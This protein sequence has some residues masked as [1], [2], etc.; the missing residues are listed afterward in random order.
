MDSSDKTPTL[1]QRVGAVLA[2]KVGKLAYEAYAQKAGGKTFDGKPMPTWDTL[3]Q[4]Q[5]DQWDFAA[6]AV[7]IGVMAVLRQVQR[8]GAPI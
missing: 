1:G 4:P 7:S 3:G 8:V 2:E 5:R 6:Q